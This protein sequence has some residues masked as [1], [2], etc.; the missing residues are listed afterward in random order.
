M[1]HVSLLLPAFV[2][3]LAA[4]STTKEGRK[5][6]RKKAAF[7]LYSVKKILLGVRNILVVRLANVRRRK[8][9][10]FYILYWKSLI[11]KILNNYYSNRSPGEFLDLRKA[12]G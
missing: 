3:T 12:A 11:D 1:V 2:S 6:E 8:W 10:K 5:E 4:H 7:E 9:M